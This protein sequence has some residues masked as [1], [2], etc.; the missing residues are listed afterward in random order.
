[1]RAERRGD[2]VPLTGGQLTDVPLTG[3][4]LWHVHMGG[5]S[6]DARRIVFTRDVDQGDLWVLENPR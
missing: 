3:G 4:E 6:P 5:F 1:M 2:P